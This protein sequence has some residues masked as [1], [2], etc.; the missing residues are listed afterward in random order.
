MKGE[1]EEKGTLSSVTLS[2][3]YFSNRILEQNSVEK[4]NCMKD[5]LKNYLLPRIQRS[6]NPWINY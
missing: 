5:F 1:G 3:D 6:H 2:Q 4:K